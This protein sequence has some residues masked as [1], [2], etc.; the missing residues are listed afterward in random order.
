MTAHVQAVYPEEGCGLLFAPPGRPAATLC[1]VENLLHSPTA[2]QMHPAELVQTILRQEAAGQEL[3]AIFHSH[4]AGPA[5]P[6]AAD[7]AQWF[8][9]AVAMFI[10]GWPLSGRAFYLN[11]HNICEVIVQM[12]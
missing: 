10:I 1:V 4:P 7:Q 11:D 2:Y 3:V 12:V 8:Y 6:S 9:P 5:T